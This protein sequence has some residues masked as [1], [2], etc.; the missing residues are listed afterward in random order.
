MPGFALIGGQHLE[1]AEQPDAECDKDEHDGKDEHGRSVTRRP[2][3]HRRGGR[4]G[5]QRIVAR[6]GDDAS[7]EAGLRF[8]LTERG[9]VSC[10]TG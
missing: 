10:V 5:P 1:Q 7:L 4:N 8:R 2:E 6:I 9:D 3:C